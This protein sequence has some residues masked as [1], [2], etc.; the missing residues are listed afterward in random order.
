MNQ[1]DENMALVSGIVG[2]DVEFDHVLYGEEFFLAKLMIPRLSG[3]VDVVPVTLPGRILATIPQRGDRVRV[4]GQIRSYNKH[5]EYGNRLMITV[6]ARTLE[7][8]EENEAPQNEMMLTGYLC[9]PV[10]FRTTPF[11]REISDMLIAINR[12]YSKSDYL[13]CIAWGRN[14]RYASEIPVGS[15]LHIHGRLQSRQYQKA[16]SDG[17][18]EER[19]A[20]E[21]SCSSIELI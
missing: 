10:V 12:P 1:T 17:N 7:P 6:F 15:R 19:T 3:T 13:P 20:Y 14:A 21:V 9:K 8:M 18:C 16:M 4:V 5:T 11:L 2:A